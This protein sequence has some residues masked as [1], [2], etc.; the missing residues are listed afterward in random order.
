MKTRTRSMAL[1]FGL[2]ALALVSSA[3]A[4]TVNMAFTGTG[5][6]GNVHVTYFGTQ[7]NVF[8]GQL[9]HTITSGTGIGAGLTGEWRTFCSDFDQHV[10]GSSSVFEIV[11][12][13]ELTVRGNDLGPGKAAALAGMYAAF[14]SSAIASSAS[15]DL[16]EA[17][18]LAVWEVLYDYNPSVGVG[19][20]S[21]G[22]GN[23]AFSQYG[24]GAFSD[25][26]INTFNG[27]LA[28]MTSGSP[29]PTLLGLE[30]GTNQD[31]LLYGSTVTVPTPGAA[32]LA[33]CGMIVCVRRRRAAA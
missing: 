18:Q 24:G 25:S 10:S 32:S 16:G 28:S 1:A 6:G 8:A 23:I 11:A 5:K 14:G 30:S 29:V 31:Q 22:G 21:L 12:P 33:L 17:F 26:L 20:I 15:N 9:K 3:G 27:L 13:A 4:D 19:S 2:A 7:I